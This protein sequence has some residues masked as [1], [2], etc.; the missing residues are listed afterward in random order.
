MTW[1]SPCSTTSEVSNDALH[2]RRVR[3]GMRGLAR[4]VA[5]ARADFVI[6]RPSSSQSRAGLS[7]TGRSSLRV[8]ARRRGRSALAGGTARTTGST[9]LCSRRRACT[10]RWSWRA[11]RSAPAR[12]SGARRVASP[13]STSTRTTRPERQVFSSSSRRR[14]AR[15]RTAAS[16]SGRRTQTRWRPDGCTRTDAVASGFANDQPEGSNHERP[17]RSSGVARPEH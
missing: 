10:R 3:L 4:A 2:R 7:D 17:C 5:R 1:R 9:G 16:P 12:R 6:G 11:Q 8:T 15:R 13:A 14:F